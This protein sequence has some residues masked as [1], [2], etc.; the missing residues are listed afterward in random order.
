[1]KFTCL[2]L[3]ALLGLLAPVVDARKCKVR[4]IGCFRDKG[5]RAI[6]GIDGS[7]PSL[8]GNYKQRKDAVKKCADVATARSKL[9]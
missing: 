9:Y 4:R 7:H 5:N 3:I 8:K 6:P 1:M 2:L